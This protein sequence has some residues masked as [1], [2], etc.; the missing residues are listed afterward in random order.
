VTDPIVRDEV[1]PATIR[2]G[3][4]VVVTGARVFVTTEDRV[5]VYIDGGTYAILADE[6]TAVR[7]VRP[8]SG[9]LELT[10]DDDTQWVVT[11]EGGCGCGSFLKRW[12]GPWQ[13]MRRGT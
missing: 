9:A 10:R 7:V 3:G 12:A 4:K 11:K 8:P 6:F 5:Y 1:F 2:T 13:P